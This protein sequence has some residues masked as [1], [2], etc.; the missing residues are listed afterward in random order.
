MILRELSGDAD[1]CSLQ[2]HL[3]IMTS[4]SKKRLMPINTPK[5]VCMHVGVTK[6][7][8]YNKGEALAPAV[9]SHKD[10]E[11]IMS[12]DRKTT[13]Y[14]LEVEVKGFKTL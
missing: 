7:N 11:V 9:R 2:A 10:L 14:C 6:V 12:R 13:A 3:N 1:V 8:R 4:W 5:Y